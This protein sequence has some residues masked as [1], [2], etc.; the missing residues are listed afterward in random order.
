MQQ[1]ATTKIWACSPYNVHLSR[2]PINLKQQIMRKDIFISLLCIFFSFPTFCPS[3][4]TPSVLTTTD[5]LSFELRQPIPDK[6][7]W[8][9]ERRRSPAIYM[10]LPEVENDG[11]FLHFKGKANL[12]SMPYFIENGNG[13]IIISGNIDIRKDETQSLCL[14]MLQTG[15]YNLIICINGNEYEA[16]FIINE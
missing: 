10:P 1:D 2:K 16:S 7:E 11:H 4:A 14:D 5:I 3:N 13:D 15:E 6:G 9:Y 12:S 8:D